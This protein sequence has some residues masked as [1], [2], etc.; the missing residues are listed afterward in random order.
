MK[1]ENEKEECALCGSP[2]VILTSDEFFKE[3]IPH[4]HSGGGLY[5]HLKNHFSGN[6]VNQ[7]LA[8]RYVLFATSR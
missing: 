8:S 7:E 5:W 1:G 2:D 6:R 3:E 4:L